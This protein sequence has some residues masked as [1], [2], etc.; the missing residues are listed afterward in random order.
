MAAWAE[1][2][3]ARFLPSRDGFAFT[4]SWPT[5]RPSAC[6]RR[7]AGSASA[8][9]PAGCAAA[10]CSARSTTGTPARPPADRPAPG[11]PLFRFIVRRLI[12]SWRIPAGVA[13]YYYW[14][15]LPERGPRGVLADDR[16]AVAADQG[17]LD[18][19]SRRRSAWS[20]SRRPIR[21]S[22]GTTIRCWPTATRAPAPSLRVYDPNS[23]PAD[24]VCIRFDPAARATAFTHNLNIGWPVRGFF[25]VPYSPAA[26]PPPP[27]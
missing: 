4:N 15:T 13:R 26:P 6:R 12:Q 23:G 21:S 2:A 18:A 20:P 7:S 16:E 1:P 5:S 8:T 24:D 11:S 17:L 22:S 14:M 9:R 19:G 27:R 3:R 10:W 25:L